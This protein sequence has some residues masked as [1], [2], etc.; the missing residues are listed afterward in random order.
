MSSTDFVSQKAKLLDDAPLC[1]LVLGANGHVS[2]VNKVFIELMGPQYKFADYPFSQA[3][4]DDEGKTLLAETIE[5]V[6]S[7]KSLRERL[8]NLQMIT[9]A[10]EA[11]LPVKAHFDLGSFQPNE[12]HPHHAVGRERAHALCERRRWLCRDRDTYSLV[13]W[14]TGRATVVRD[15]RG[16]VALTQ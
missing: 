2:L 3:P 16:L 11:G 5:K 13:R 12:W 9:L 1:A 6:R 7:G 14:S 8:R 15:S 4:A 10:G